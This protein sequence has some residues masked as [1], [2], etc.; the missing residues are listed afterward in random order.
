MPR[1]VRVLTTKLRFRDGTANAA[2][3]VIGDSGR[4]RPRHEE[5]V[6]A[7]AQH[8]GR[9]L[10]PAERHLEDL[11]RPV[12]GAPPPEGRTA[13]GRPGPSL[14]EKLLAAVLNDADSAGRPV[15]SPKGI[16]TP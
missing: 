11:G 7:P 10:G 12:P 1:S 8:L 3:L 16:R 15:P 9:R 2:P 4:H 13:L 6:D 14:A 5:V